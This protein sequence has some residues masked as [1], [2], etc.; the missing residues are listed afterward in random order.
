MR[1]KTAVTFEFEVRQPLTFRSEI[2]ATAPNTIA[3]RAIREARNV[4]RP[5]NWTSISILLDRVGDSSD[6]RSEEEVSDVPE[7]IEGESE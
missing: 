4:L 5:I 2:T 1:C 3:S 6:E 7:G